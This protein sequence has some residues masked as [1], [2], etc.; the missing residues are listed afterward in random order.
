MHMS[1]ALRWGR[2]QCK[3]AL[4]W[5]GRTFLLTRPNFFLSPLHQSYLPITS[6]AALSRTGCNPASVRLTTTPRLLPT[7]TIHHGSQASFARRVP[8]HGAVMSCSGV[9]S[10]IQ[11]GRVREVSVRPDAGDGLL[12]RGHALHGTRCMPRQRSSARA[13]RCRADPHK[14][15]GSASSETSTSPDRDVSSSSSTDSELSDGKTAQARLWCAWNV[16][17]T[18]T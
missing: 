10:D 15:L 4:V 9:S 3:S 1:Y 14:E 5:I 2:L 6:M 13:V 7:R 17:P 8:A 18:C 12:L 11:F 16:S